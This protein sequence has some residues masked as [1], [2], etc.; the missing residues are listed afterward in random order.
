MTFLAFANGA[1]D[2]IGAITAANSD[3]GGVGLA[4]GGIMGAGLFVTGVVSAFVI[5]M[6]P[7]PILINSW[8]FFWDIG[9]Y[10][11]AI[12]ILIAASFWGSL[13]LFFSICFLVWYGIFIVFVTIEDRK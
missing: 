2:V 8:V 3:T 4:V 7:K 13:N 9:F 6:S 1:P 12:L 10:M 5:F 11:G